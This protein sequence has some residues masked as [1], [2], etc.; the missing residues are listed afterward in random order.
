MSMNFV[1]ASGKP[2]DSSEIEEALIWVK[3]RIVRPDFSDPEG[4]ILCITI[5]DA[6]EELLAM[7][8]VIQKMREKGK[9]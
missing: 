7:R 4:V 5:K 2:R 6:L 1:D 3:K 9:E 8:E